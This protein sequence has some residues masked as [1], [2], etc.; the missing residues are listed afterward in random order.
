MSEDYPEIK[1]VRRTNSGR[2]IVFDPV[3]QTLTTEKANSLD[4]N[5]ATN[6]ETVP[7]WGSRVS[8]YEETGSKRMIATLNLGK[9]DWITNMKRLF[10]LIREIYVMELPD[11][12][13]LS[14]T[15]DA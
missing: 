10:G 14:V 8:I 13:T 15:T 7:K 5:K 12:H 2:V 6:Y 11:K 4:I 9:L 1:P 3:K